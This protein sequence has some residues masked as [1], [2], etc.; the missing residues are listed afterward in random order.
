M[1]SCKIDPATKQDTRRKHVFIISTLK[2]VKLYIQTTSDKEFSSWLDAIMRELVARK[3]GSIQDKG[4]YVFY[5]I[6][7]QKKICICETDITS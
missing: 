1:D 7:L 5:F 6:F 2:K 3:E 4:L